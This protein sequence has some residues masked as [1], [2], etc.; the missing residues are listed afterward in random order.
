MNRL[1]ETKKDMDDKI[2]SHFNVIVIVAQSY[3]M[4]YIF[5]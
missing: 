4:T 3:I 2:Y 5:Q 1:K